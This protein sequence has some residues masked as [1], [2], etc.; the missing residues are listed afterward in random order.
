M[1]TSHGNYKVEP[2][3]RQNI[4][5]LSTVIVQEGEDRAGNVKNVRELVA[6]VL[7]LEQWWLWDFL[8]IGILEQQSYWQK[9]GYFF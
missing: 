5:K 1:S 7:G 2:D 8:I 4:L 9:Q 3:K 6:F